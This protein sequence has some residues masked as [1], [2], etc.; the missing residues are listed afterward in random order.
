M[1]HL[2][3]EGNTQMNG[4]VETK[5]QCL[6]LNFSHLLFRVAQNREAATVRDIKE[7]ES[8]GRVRGGRSACVF[9]FPIS[10]A[11]CTLGLAR[12]SWRFEIG[13]LR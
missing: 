9:F 1:A 7:G 5:N 11:F 6:C 13:Q 2:W 3:D 4:R 10:P 8:T 12:S